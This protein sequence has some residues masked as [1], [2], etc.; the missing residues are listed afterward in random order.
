VIN[1]FIKKG[2]LV[3]IFISLYSFCSDKSYK[4]RLKSYP[5]RSSASKKASVEKKKFCYDW[6]SAFFQ[7]TTMK[8]LLYNAPKTMT[9]LF[10]FSK[11]PKN[12]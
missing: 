10:C 3:V 7:A 2:F 9:N 4:T 5:C 1:Y 8:N 6:T 12:D 11:K